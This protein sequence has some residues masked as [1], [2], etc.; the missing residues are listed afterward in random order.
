MCWQRGW[1]SQLGSARKGGADNGARDDG[2][3]VVFCLVAAEGARGRGGPGRLRGGGG[4][5]RD[6]SERVQ[7]D[8]GGPRGT[9]ECGPGARTE[10]RQREHGAASLDGEARAPEPSGS[11]EG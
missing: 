3:S 7:G 6:A 11:G 2:R 10:N 5:G 1:S 8:G 4:Y 9:D